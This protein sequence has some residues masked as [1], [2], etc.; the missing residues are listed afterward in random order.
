MIMES[1]A[2][3]IFAL[4]FLLGDYRNTAMAFIFLA[5]WEAHYMHRAFIYPLTL[6]GPTKRIPAVIVGFGLF[7]NCINAYLNGRYLFGFSG[8]YPD[9][10]LLDPRF[11]LGLTLFV[12][13]F[14]V[15]RQSD[16]ILLD[17]RKAGKNSYK[18]PQGGFYR[19]VSSPNYLGEIAI[20]AGWAL[21][22][23]SLP[24]LAFAVWTMANLIPRARANHAWYKAKF[25]DYPPE[26]RV[27]IPRLW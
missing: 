9:A 24:G 18:V 13:G 5:M 6:H 22:T 11:V 2:A 12:M 25:A 19:W 23:W 16:H 4:F 20:W 8:G 10:W 15:N 7:F 26:R 1:V 14:L 17:L 21:A 27:L 3:L